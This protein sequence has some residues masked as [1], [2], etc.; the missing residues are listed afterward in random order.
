MVHFFSLPVAVTPD[1]ILKICTFLFPF[2]SKNIF[3]R[4]CVYTLWGVM[5]CVL[6]EIGTWAFLSPPKTLIPTHRIFFNYSFS[7]LSGR[8]AFFSSLKTLIE[9]LLPPLFL[10][11]LF[12]FLVLRLNLSKGLLRFFFFRTGIDPLPH[13]CVFCVGLFEIRFR[14]RGCV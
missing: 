8:N 7:N 14:L 6:L 9:H 10:G 3:W 2:C 12:R 5:A 1:I 4:F 11:V 13:F